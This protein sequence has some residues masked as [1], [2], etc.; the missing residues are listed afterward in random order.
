MS[1]CKDAPDLNKDVEE[2]YK[3]NNRYDSYTNL[4]LLDDKL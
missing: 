4:E 3:V 1:D 2:Y